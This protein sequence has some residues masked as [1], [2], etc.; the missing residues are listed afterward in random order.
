MN[1][2]GFTGTQRG[3][4]FRQYITLEVHLHKFSFS[5]ARFHH[6]DCVGADAEASEIARRLGFRIVAHPP[7]NV[8]KRAYV[9]VDEVFPP[10]PYLER[11]H[12][13]VSVTDILF[14]CPGEVPEQLRSGTWATLRYARKLRKKLC[15]IFPDGA[16]KDSF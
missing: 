8:K 15:I 11:N 4:T 14:A 1:A 2:V 10:R 7:T 9:P 5:D 6:G 16:V 12:V 3:L 13:I